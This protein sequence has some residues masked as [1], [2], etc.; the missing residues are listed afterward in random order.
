MKKN[1]AC[2]SQSHPTVVQQTGV[3]VFPARLPHKQ[4]LTRG[5]ILIQH[6][7]P[8]IDHPDGEDKQKLIGILE[9]LPP[10]T[11][12]VCSGFSGRTN[13]SSNRR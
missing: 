13:Q 11:Q 3:S 12:N 10:P 9:S 8:R 1:S 4:L 5:L 7:L 6:A 2:S